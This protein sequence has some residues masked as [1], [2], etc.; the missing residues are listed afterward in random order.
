MGKKSPLKIL[1]ATQTIGLAAYT[2]FTAQAQGIDLLAVFLDNL[3]SLTWSGQ[4]N[5]DFLCY[6]ILSG[7][8]IM[9]RNAFSSQSILIGIIATLLGI[10][11][12][13]PYLI[14]LITK[15]KGDLKRVFIG[16]R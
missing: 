2:Y 4:F 9:W 8:W 12:F 3:S 7:L 15:E 1:L 13:A 16:N 10:V 6:L 11:F 14:W 5:L